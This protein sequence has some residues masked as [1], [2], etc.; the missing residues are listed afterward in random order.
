MY[1]IHEYNHKYNHIASNTNF[2]GDPLNSPGTHSNDHLWV[3]GTQY[4]EKI[5]TS[6]IKY[7][8]VNC[9]I[10]MGRSKY[11]S[12]EQRNLIKK[13]IGEGKTYEQVQ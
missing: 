8:L 12:A 13:L 7:I 10:K 2:I 1:I 11:W 9:K 3:P 4:I 6:L 5:F